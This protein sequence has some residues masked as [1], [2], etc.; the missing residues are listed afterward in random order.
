MIQGRGDTGG[1]GMESSSERN[2]AAVGGEDG[3]MGWLQEW[4][5]DNADL[6]NM[7]L[8]RRGFN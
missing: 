4:D 5:K 6:G 8:N 3:V 2:S 7:C 1:S